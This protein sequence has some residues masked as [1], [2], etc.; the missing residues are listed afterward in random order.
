MPLQ[1]I[2][3]IAHCAAN[4]RL[5][6]LCEECLKPLLLQW[7]GWWNNVHVEKKKARCEDTDSLMSPCVLL[8]FLP[9]CNNCVTFHYKCFSVL[10]CHFFYRLAL[11]Q[12][13]VQD[14]WL[15]AGSVCFGISLHAGGH[16][17]WKVSACCG[18]KAN[19]K[20]TKLT[21][22]LIWQKIRINKTSTRSPHS[23]SLFSM[24]WCVHTESGT[25][26]CSVSLK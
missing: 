6:S 15:C 9:H 24:L 21:Q 22:L 13:R 19:A 20:T 25:N 14:E 3:N 5:Y 2:V 1:T 11:F 7:Q 16:C 18:L 26:Y 4:S 23:L 10:M 12:L 17:C 8:L